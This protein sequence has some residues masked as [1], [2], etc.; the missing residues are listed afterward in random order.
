MRQLEELRRFF[1]P[2][3]GTETI[4]A[5]Q[6]TFS[7]DVIVSLGEILNNELAAFSAPA[8]VNRAFGI[9][10][11]MAQNV[12][13]YSIERKVTVSGGTAGV[14]SII[15]ARTPKHLVIMTSNLIAPERMPAI[16]RRFKE[17]NQMEPQELRNTYQIKRRNQYHEDSF[18]AG[19]GLLDIARRSG[20]QLGHGFLPEGKEQLRFFF[21]V[22]VTL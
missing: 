3:S 14:G 19:L 9:F 10:V 18:G 8:A 6:G 20:H 1:S 7:Q 16:K 4:L 22:V 17:I 13:H 12:L 2:I 15:V 5:F 11:E 21:R